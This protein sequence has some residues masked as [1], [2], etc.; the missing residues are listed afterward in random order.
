M[1]DHLLL[2]PSFPSGVAADAGFLAMTLSL[3]YPK[4]WVLWHL[5]GVG[6]ALLR[7]YSG[8][9]CFGDVIGGYLIG[10]LVVGLMSFMLK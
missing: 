4:Y 9:H 2:S 7:V 3:L 8:A 5:G 1:G 6:I 10:V